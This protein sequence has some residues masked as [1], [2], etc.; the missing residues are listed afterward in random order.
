M[1]RELDESNVPALA[2]AL[3]NTSQTSKDFFSPH[4]F[5][6][7]SI[8]N[9][10]N[11]DGNYYYLFFDEDNSFAGYG[12]LRTF[13]KYAIPTLGC[14][15][16]EKYRGRGY[17]KKLVEELLEKAREL[18]FESVKLKV[19]PDNVIAHELYKKIG[20]KDI[21]ESDDGQIWMEYRF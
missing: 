11:N 4:D 7:E 17:G 6:I 5:N 15:I 12:M 2:E 13:G 21:G 10:L 16:W 18:N 3:Q 9:L 1:L 14:I 20:F 8:R 19:Y